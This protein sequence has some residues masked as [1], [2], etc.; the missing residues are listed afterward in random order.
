MEESFTIHPSIALQFVRVLICA[1]R[2]VRSECTI[3]RGKL[4]ENDEPSGN[5][6]NRLRRDN[7]FVELMLC[8]G[9]NAFGPVDDVDFAVIAF[10]V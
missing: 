5:A 4:T 10:V 9:L 6:I 8:I 3:L 2:C 7:T 1:I